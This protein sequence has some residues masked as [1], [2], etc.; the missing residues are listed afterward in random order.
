MKTLKEAYESVGLK[1]EEYDCVTYVRPN[2][3]DFEITLYSVKED[4]F[5]ADPLA[6]LYGNI[7]EYSLTNCCNLKIHRNGTQIYP[8]LHS[9]GIASNV[10][11]CLQDGNKKD[12]VD[13]IVQLIDAK[14]KEKM[15]DKCNS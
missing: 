6:T 12:A 7:S 10:L 9:H 2:C 8:V 5:K 1:P 11:R 3:K 13:W 4:F 15:G 14:I